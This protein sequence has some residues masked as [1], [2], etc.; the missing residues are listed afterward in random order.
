DV[1]AVQACIAGQVAEALQIALA[2]SAR[3]QLAVVPTRS[4]DAYARYLRSRELRRGE[5]SPEALRGAIA[6]LE[7]AVMLDSTFVAAWSDLAQL[8]VEAFY[9]GGTQAGDANAAAD[10]LRRAKALAPASPDV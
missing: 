4:L 1:F 9:L 5:M 10:A 6:E 8:H 3:A 7:Q 2:D